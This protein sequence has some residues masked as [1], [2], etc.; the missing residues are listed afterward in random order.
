MLR[1]MTVPSNNGLVDG[2]AYRLLMQFFT[3]GSYKIEV[4]Q[5]FFLH[6]MT[7]QN[8][9]PRYLKHVMTRL[10]ILDRIWFLRRGGEVF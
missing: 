7:V 6:T 9:H 10:R 4:L 2:P 3:L 5:T 1:L 8:N